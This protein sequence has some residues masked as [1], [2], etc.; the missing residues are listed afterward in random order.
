ML[1]ERDNKA[2]EFIKKNPCRSDIIH[3]LFY[4]SYRVAMYRLEKMVDEGYC[5]RY[6]ENPNAKYFYYTG[7]KPRQIE[8]MDMAA[9]SIL[10]IRSKGYEVLNF[11]REVKLD[12]A[13]PDAVIG[14]QKSNEY[15]VLMIEIERFNNTLNK[16]ISIYEKVYRERKY[17][18]SFKILYVCSKKVRSPVVPIIC[19][20][21]KEFF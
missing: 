14:I 19:I 17:F 12:G 8:H 6:R 20:N 15:G 10:W 13:R 2:L 7:N 16:K 4:P 9:R 5:K 11:R 3:I 18:N 1:T 21:P